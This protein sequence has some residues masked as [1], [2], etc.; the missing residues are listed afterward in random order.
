MKNIEPEFK[1]GE[2]A[3]LRC[4]KLKD[5][6]EAYV[7]GLNDPV[8]NRYMEIGKGKKQTIDMVCDYVLDQEKRNDAFLFGLFIGGKLRGTCRIHNISP[9]DADIG[10]ALFDRSIWGHGWA[11]RIVSVVSEYTFQKY[12]CR[13]LK[14]GIASA[15]IASK[16]VFENAGFSLAKVFEKMD[17]RYPGELWILDRKDSENQ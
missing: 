1:L 6:T 13:Q 16:K 8:V 3:I 9:K 14:A 11:T 10:I 4:L 12:S 15:N 2:D 5:V 7:N 17:P